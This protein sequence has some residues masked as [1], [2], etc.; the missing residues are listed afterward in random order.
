MMVS[1]Q[2]I[3]YRRRNLIRDVSNTNNFRSME[4]F[5]LLVK[6]YRYIY[7]GR[8]ISPI[9]NR[10]ILDSINDPQ[11]TRLLDQADK[12]LKIGL[13]ASLGV[14]AIPAIALSINENLSLNQFNLTLGAGFVSYFVGLKNLASWHKTTL[15]AV[16]RYNAVITRDE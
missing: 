3:Q 10:D 12:E 1:Q 13:L 14:F 15:A 16:K 5:A 2:H 8:Y 6:K 7:R 11:V 4:N 9:W